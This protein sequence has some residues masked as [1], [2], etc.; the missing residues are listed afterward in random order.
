VVLGRRAQH[1]R[2]ADVDV[3]DRVFVACSRARGRLR[4][5]VE[6]DDQQVDG[7][8]AVARG[9]RWRPCV[10]QVAPAEQAAVDAAGAAS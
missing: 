3:L 1:R 9:Q 2:A 10:R 7:L 5:R 4:E 8:D 6:V